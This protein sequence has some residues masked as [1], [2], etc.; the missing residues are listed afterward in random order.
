[1]VDSADLLFELGTEELP[2][3]ALKRLSD[4]LT[5]EFTNGL[6]KLNITHGVVQS[7]ATPR[8]L[9]L[10]ISDCSLSQADRQV[11]RRGPAIAAAFDD[12]GNPTKAAQGFARSCGVEVSDLEQLETDK[13]TWLVYRVLEKGKAAS[14]I[15]PT[16]AEEALAKLPIPKRMR[17]GSS[18]AQFVRPVHW[19]LFLLGDSIV[20]CTIL[21][22]KAGNITYGHRF[23]HPSS[24]EIN[25]ACDYAELLQNE[26]S[27]IADFSV[28]KEKIR[29]QVIETAQALDG[30]AV[31]DEAL[32]DEV[33]GLVEWPVPIAADFEERFLEVPHEALII[34]MKKN[35]KYFH[36]VNASGELM[37]HFITL[38]NVES[39]NPTAI[40]EGN[41]RV[42]RPRL[43]D[44]MFFWQQDAKHRLEDRLESLKSV[45]FQ[46]K[47]GSMFEKSQRVAALA[48]DIANT[49]GSDAEQAHRAGILSRCDLMTEMVGEFAD[50]QGIMGRYQA[51][52]D[53]ESEAIVNAMEEFYLPRYS[54]GPLPTTPAG[55]A[56]SLAE[57][58]DTLVGIFGIGMKTT[59]DKDPFA[60]R[61]AALGA[62]RIMLEH[63]LPVDLKVLLNT[64][65]TNLLDKKPA[66]DTC[67]QVYRFM[68]DRLKGIYLDKKVP[69]G[70]FEAVAAIKPDN[71]ADFDRR[72][73]AVMT[74]Q[75]LEE[76]SALAAANKRISNILKK[77]G[78]SA[79][80]G[81]ADPS[82]FQD[83]EEQALF[84]K[85]SSKS[86]HIVPLL[87]QYDYE[88]TL[89]ALAELRDSVDQFF[90]KVMVMAD[91]EAIK[92]NRLALLGNLNRLFLEVADISKLQA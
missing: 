32:L 19:L 38:A 81:N 24:L 45:V 58:I 92:N 68:L 83:A 14:E 57:K 52:R 79:Q 1:M 91:D 67:E 11:E 28:R 80:Q 42:V 74:F 30:Q 56:L 69:V 18:N 60:L 43:A 31:I 35:Q 16:I 47:L 4:A 64:A 77:S 39:T 22:A 29:S 53:G 72:I 41:E 40:K 49:I 90:D 33:T 78:T 10:T 51:A 15:L 54:G 61:R 88:G 62:L 73:T 3:V 71:V 76:S 5:Q 66:E 46:H 82:L 86:A 55:I 7:Y 27:V 37:N 70:V 21:D 12:A 34:T 63:N 13:G 36:M 84:D 8:R 87:E 85:V 2:P 23:H 9:A 6:D 48:K 44:A 17:W 65:F 26:A 50:M 20:P 75:T 59:G 89:G 25:N